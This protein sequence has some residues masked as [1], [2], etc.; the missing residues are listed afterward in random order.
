[1]KISLDQIT[2]TPKD[3]SFSEKIDEMNLIYTEESDR[4]FR[5]PSSIDVNLAYYR[6]GHEI[7]FQGRLGGIIEGR[8]GRCLERYPFPIGKIFHLVLTPEPLPPKSKELNRNELGLSFYSAQEINLYPFIR[9]QVLLALPM[10]PLCED[11]CRGLCEGCGV[12][13]NHELCLCGS[14]PGDP[15][16]TLFRTL[17]LSQ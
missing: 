14:S 15:R 11:D 7:F 1:M 16:L 5:F 2:E 9:E 6:S 12:N 3:I 8:C 10:R 4:D 17:K 13:L